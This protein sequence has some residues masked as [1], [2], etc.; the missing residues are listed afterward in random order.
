MELGYSFDHLRQH[1]RNSFTL[2]S[3][4]ANHSPDTALGDLP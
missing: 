4:A 2:A 1:R 3:G